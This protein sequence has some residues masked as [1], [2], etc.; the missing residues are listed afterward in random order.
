[1]VFSVDAVFIVEPASES[2]LGVISVL[3]AEALMVMEAAFET[4]VAADLL[5]APEPLFELFMKVTSKANRR[6]VLSGEYDPI[7]EATVEGSI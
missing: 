5:L 6:S 2:S 3:S 7:Q 4:D 1:V